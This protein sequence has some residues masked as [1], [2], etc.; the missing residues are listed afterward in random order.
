MSLTRLTI[1]LLVATLVAAFLSF[2]GVR[3]RLE[4]DMT[5]VAHAGGHMYV[6][7]FPALPSLTDTKETPERS[8]LRVH[9]NRR[10]L[11]PAHSA[12]D[13]ISAS[14]RGRFRHLDNHVYFAA[15]DNTDVR[16][17][18]RTYFATYYWKLNPLAPL[19]LGAIGTL[20]FVR[21]RLW[22][23]FVPPFKRAVARIERLWRVPR[24]N[25]LPILRAA[26]FIFAAAAIISALLALSGIE[27][28][29]VLDAAR[30]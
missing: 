25:R 15:S 6:V 9:E 30:A 19:L 10:K 12:L 26:A 20:L 28:R 1:A 13:D 22:V 24:A 11:G 17:N 3:Q 29:V 2:V 16:A 27:R 18:G 23:P 8:P 7:P 21:V 14:G 5:R 4:W